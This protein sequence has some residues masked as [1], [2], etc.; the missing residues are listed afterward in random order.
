LGYEIKTDIIRANIKESE[1][2]KVESELQREFES[3]N[4]NHE[5]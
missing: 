2:R 3:L 5:T 4:G 1:L